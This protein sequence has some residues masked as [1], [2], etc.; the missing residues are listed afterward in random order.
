[1]SWKVDEI[2]LHRLRSLWPAKN[3]GFVKLLEAAGRGLILG[4]DSFAFCLMSML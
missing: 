3:V 2:S 1:M 4:T